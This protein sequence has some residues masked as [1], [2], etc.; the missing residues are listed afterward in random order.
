MQLLVQ[1][2]KSHTVLIRS[3]LSISQLYYKHF[4]NAWPPHCGVHGQD[5]TSAK[6]YLQHK[7]VTRAGLC[8]AV[9]MCI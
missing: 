1:N 9:C 6:T 2:V 7:I 8:H 5:I 4:Q 3:H